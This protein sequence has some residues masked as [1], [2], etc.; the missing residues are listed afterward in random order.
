MVVHK[1]CQ[2][3]DTRKQCCHKNNIRQIIR[4]LAFPQ[5]PV[6]TSMK[7]PSYLHITNLISGSWDPGIKKRKEEK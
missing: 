5:T 3:L 4:V 2:F 1:A 7:S 6:Y